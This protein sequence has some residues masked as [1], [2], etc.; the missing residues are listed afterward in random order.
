MKSPKKLVI[1]A[2]HYFKCMLKSSDACPVFYSPSLRE[3]TTDTDGGIVVTFTDDNT[4]DR[5]APRK[6][7]IPVK[8]YEELPKYAYV[9]FNDD[10][11]TNGAPRFLT[12]EQFDKVQGSKPDTKST[13]VTKPV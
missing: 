4:S 12:V 10:A 13:S 1:V 11:V 5:Q 7:Y 8:D 2:T 3:N 6:I 9:N